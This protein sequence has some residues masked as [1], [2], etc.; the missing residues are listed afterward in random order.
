MQKVFDV[1]VFGGGIVGASIFNKLCRI[2]KKCVLIEKNDIAS[3]ATK[4]NS[5]IIH[6]GFD[7]MPG[8][9]KAKFNVL[10]S[11][12][13][14]AICKRLGVPYKKIGAYVLGNDIDVVN[15]L[16]ARGIKNGLTKN[17]MKILNQEQLKSKIPNLNENITYGL[18]AKNS[19]IVN[20]YLLTICL[21]E[22]AVINGGK[23]YTFFDT[24]SI[25]NENNHFDIF[26][27][28]Q[29]I[30]AKQIINACGY[31]YNDLAE[32]LGTEKYEIE[33]KRGEYFVLD[34]TEK[35]ITPATLF[36]LPSKLGKGVLVTPTVDGNI[37]VGPN[38]VTGENITITTTDG[39][40]DIKQKSASLITNINLKKTIRQFSGIRCIVGNDFVVEKSKKVP[41]VIN[42]AGICS[43][44]LS[45]APAIA[46]YVVH[47]L[48]YKN[49]EK[50]F[51][52]LQPYLLAKD[53]S[54]KKYNA[55]V[56]QNPS[57]GK[58]IC[59]CEMITQGDIEFAL[60]RPI[61][62]STIDGIKRRVRAGM[63]RCQGGFCMDK[64]AKIIAKE[65]KIDLLDVTKEYPNSNIYVDNID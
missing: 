8:T 47:L 31:G 19:A 12:I 5:A 14:P 50:K 33:Y 2:G 9:L 40:N 48:G 25:K 35:H 43:P 3:G 49:I 6:A 52:K 7:A 34:N 1:A 28:N 55:L 45:S 44:G 11:K 46:E 22:E 17:Y 13:Y 65:N 53:L 20:P 26:G 23:C 42:I 30:L 57:Y 15:E 39:L 37:L 18:Y 29:H 38:A 63:G 64:V 4:A 54:S 32:I 56:R 41:R 62:V 58:V 61:K 27:N 36:P 51:N 16:Y 10:G 24:K 60:H 21:C 59:K